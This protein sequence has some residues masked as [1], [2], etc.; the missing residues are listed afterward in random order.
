MRGTT[1]RTLRHKSRKRM[2]LKFY[3]TVTLPCL[4]C[5]SEIFTRKKWRKTNRSRRYAVP[6]V[7]NRDKERSG[8]IRS[9]LGMRK[10]DKH[11]EKNWLERLQRMSPGTAHKQ[12]LCYQSTGR[13]RECRRLRTQ[14][15]NKLNPYRWW[16]WWS[17]GSIH[18]DVHAIYEF[19]CMANRIVTHCLKLGL[20][21]MWSMC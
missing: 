8:A 7:C 15:A 2:Q 14:R 19:F 11:T 21:L 1:K 5:D 12:L 10:L 13:C 20:S 18:R 17:P 3:K 6:T 9:Q 4:I 16:W